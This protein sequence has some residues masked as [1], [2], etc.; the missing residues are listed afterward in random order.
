MNRQQRIILLEGQ[1]R[2]FT[3]GSIEYINDQWVFFDDE[4]EE[5]SLL[6]DNLHQEIEI[7]QNKVW[8]KGILFEEG[9]V[10][11]ADDVLTLK[12]HDKIRVRRHLVYSLER[13]L[14]ELHD[15]ALIHFVTTL[16]S[17]KFSIYDCIYCYNH[18]TFLNKEQ[19]NSGVNF[20]VFDNQEHICTVQHHFSYFEKISDRFEFTLN[21]GKRLIIEKIS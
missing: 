18:L 7:F 2:A 14:E 20:I 10:G 3:M 17:L 9:K 4:T 8:R 6:D 11:F 12:N 21:S 19:P 16:N 1:P 13:L 15:E 5:A